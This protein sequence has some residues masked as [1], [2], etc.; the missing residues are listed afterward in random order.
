MKEQHELLTG[1]FTSESVY[2]SDFPTHKPL[3]VKLE[4][5]A[6]QKTQSALKFDSRTMYKDTFYQ[7]D[8]QKLKSF[9]ELPSFTYSV[10]YPDRGNPV[11]K[12]SLKNLIHSGEFAAKPGSLAPREPSIKIGLEGTHDMVTTNEDTFKTHAGFVR[13]QPV[14]VVSEWKPR[15]KFECKT[16]A[17]DDFK[18]FG[19][20]MPDKRK[21]ITPPPETID[22]KVD[23]KQYFETTKGREHRVTWD[24]SKVHRPALVRVEERY[25][26]PKEKFEAFSVMR[27]D[28]KEHR[29]VRPVAIEQPDQ[30]KVTDAKFFSDTSYKTQFPKYDSVEVKR[31]GDPCEQRYYVR[32][33]GKFPEEPSVMRGDFRSHGEVR[34]RSPILPEN[35]RHADG[36]KFHGETSYGSEFTQKSL[37]P[38]TFKQMLAEKDVE[39]LRKKVSDSLQAGPSSFGR[40]R[41]KTKGLTAAN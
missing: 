9:Q 19:K 32:P 36:G 5:P 20:K 40:F 38:C 34:P 13:E 22:L 15:P 24:K 29:D 10:L 21:P 18:G 3:P 17:Q 26:A 7:K 28:F 6:T 4:R 2:R 8:Q 27:S 37:Q 33:F 11:D 25:S 35:K 12:I 39:Q 23:N 14:K 30:T 31:Y 16:Q 1:A 41:K